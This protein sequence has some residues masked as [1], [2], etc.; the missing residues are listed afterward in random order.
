MLKEMVGLS[1]NFKERKAL[2]ENEKLKAIAGDAQAAYAVAALS[3]MDRDFDTAFEYAK[4]SVYL[5]NGKNHEALNILGDCYKHGLGCEKDVKKAFESFNQSAELGNDEAQW[6]LGVMYIDGR[7]VEK[8]LVKAI[9]WLTKSAEVGNDMGQH[10]LGAAQA[11]K[12]SGI[13]INMILQDDNG[14]IPPYMSFMIGSRQ[15]TL[16]NDEAYFHMLEYFIEQA[17]NEPCDESI[18]LVKEIA[19]HGI[20]FYFEKRDIYNAELVYDSV[21][22]FKVDDGCLD[23]NFILM[24]WTLE[25][26][27]GLLKRAA[28]EKDAVNHIAKAVEYM[29]R[30]YKINPNENIRT[31]LIIQYRQAA[32][33]FL[34]FNDEDNANHYAHLAEKTYE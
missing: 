18:R 14:E 12:E 8:D 21:K 33:T 26:N 9:F 27:Y 31:H 15:V 13:N 25:S 6:K 1:M 11:A 34:Q 32:D 30:L 20:G 10:Y 4:L 23:F 24:D 5:S 22:F 3:N 29:E 19:V 28:N 7:V 17:R 16:K 2:L